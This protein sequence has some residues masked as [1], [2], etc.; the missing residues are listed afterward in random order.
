M[1]SSNRVVREGGYL[2]EEQHLLASSLV[3]GKA[4]NRLAL[5]IVLGVLT[6]FAVTTAG[7]FSGFEPLRIDAFIPA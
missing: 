1:M 5:G 4:Q 6:V 2:Q 7:L 3:P